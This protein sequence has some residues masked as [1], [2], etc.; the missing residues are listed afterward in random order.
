MTK[1]SL[2]H[3]HN[4]FQYMPLTFVNLLVIDS[5]IITQL[6]KLAAR[7]IIMLAILP[8]VVCLIVCV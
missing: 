4:I 2:V 7:G 1:V 8:V 5:F 3:C 6:V